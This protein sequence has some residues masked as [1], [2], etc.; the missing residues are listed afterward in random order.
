[1][2]TQTSCSQRIYLIKVILYGDVSTSTTVLPGGA[3]SVLNL[4]DGTI[5]NV[6]D[7]LFQS[8]PD[9]PP[10][11]GVFVYTIEHQYLKNGLFTISYLEPN[12]NFGVLNMDNSGQTTFYTATTVAVGAQFCNSLPVLLAPPVDRACS[13]LAFFHNP[14]AFDADGD[15]LSF[16]LAIPFSDNGLQVSNYRSP[17][18]PGFYL[19]PAIGNEAGTTPATFTINAFDGTIIWDAPGAI[20]EYNIAFEV[21]EW[22]KIEGVYYSVGVVRRDMQIIVEECDNQRPDLVIPE[23]ICVVAGTPISESIFGTDPDGHDVKIEVFSGIFLL[24]NNPAIFSPNPA[25]FQTS[26]PQAALSFEWTPSCEEVRNQ[27][28]QII[29]KITDKPPSGPSLVRFKTWNIKVAA[30]APNL[31]NADLDILQRQATISWSPYVCTNATAIQVWRRVSSF[32]YNPNDCVSGLPK[33]A[34]YTK[35]ADV[36]PD[37]TEFTD[38]NGGEGLAPGAVYCYR[39]TAI[40]PLVGGAESKVSIEICLPPILADAPV[41]THVTVDKTSEENGEVTISWRSPYDLDQSEY[42][43]PYEYVMLRANGLTGDDG[44]TTVQLGGILDTTYTDKGLN[45]QNFAYNYRIVLLAKQSINE[46]IIPIDTSATASSVWNG[47]TPVTGSIEVRWDALTPWSNFSQDYPMHLIYRSSETGGYENL[48][49]IDSVNVFENGFF[50]LDDGSFQ[51]LGLNEHEYYCYRIK[52]RGTYGNPEIAAPQENFSQLFCSTTLDIIPPCSPELMQ[53]ELDC[54]LFNSQTPCSQTTFAHTISWTAPTEEICVNDIY[55][56][57][58]Y[59]SDSMNVGFKLIG[60]S[61]GN[62]FT[63]NGLSNLKRCYKIASVDRAGNESEFSDSICFDNCPSIYFPNVFTPNDDLF[64][65]YFSNFN[66]EQTCLRFVK[67]IS[68]SVFNR[69]GNKIIDLGGDMPL[70]WDG[71]DSRGNKVPIGVYFFK[72]DVFVDVFDSNNQLRQLKG[73]IHVTY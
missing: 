71:R 36:L 66:D 72:A 34:G 69:W 9:L 56:Y 8:R 6:P 49:L 32:Q 73:W 19:N 41:I 53:A 38:T 57:N 45:T 64:N 67:S 68:L 28:Y 40:F 7:G 17:N 63:E 62:E 14:G 47:A 4:G 54:D 15:S 59:A 33:F 51:N 55:F 39:L 43:S 16:K 20:G 37:A 27:P 24:P 11:L 13:S 12:R 60:S 1:V 42:L 29:V 30:P 21:E 26:V 10:G 44:L 50:Y 70:T 46:P 18:H 61:F 58:V 22:R 31:S 25:I 23:D 52:T 35:V 5:L 3:G 2:V 48:V 65:A